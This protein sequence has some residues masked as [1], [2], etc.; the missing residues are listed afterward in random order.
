VFSDEALTGGMVV[1]APLPGAHGRDVPA[2]RA[3]EC[4]LDERVNGRLR[5]TCSASREAHAVFLEQYA[6]GWSATVDGR[7]APLLRA[8]LAARAVPI[9]AGVHT[10]AMSYRVPGLRVGAAV[11]L[12]CAAVVILLW[13]VPTWYRRRSPAGGS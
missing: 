10:I 1:L 9:P 3:G 11:S 6:D 5:A 2:G 4:R 12:G 7:P 8:N 13:L